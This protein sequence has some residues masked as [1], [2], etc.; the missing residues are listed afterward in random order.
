MA[1]FSCLQNEVNAV[2]VVAMIADNSTVAQ[3]WV[4]YHTASDERLQFSILSVR[5]TEDVHILL[6]QS[7]ARQFS[8]E[9]CS[10]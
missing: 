7:L 9:N 6:L 8:E 10:G 5:S 3:L 4:W 2:A 1:I